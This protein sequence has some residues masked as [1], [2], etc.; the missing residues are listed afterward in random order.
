MV[1]LYTQKVN[2]V[3]LWFLIQIIGILILIYR[4]KLKTLQMTIFKFSIYGTK[5]KKS[6]KID[7]FLYWRFKRKGHIPANTLGQPVENNL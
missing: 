1:T 7:N 4:T 3:C 2:V 6:L 5:Q